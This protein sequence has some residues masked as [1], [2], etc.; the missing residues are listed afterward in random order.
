M[1]FIELFRLQRIIVHISFI[2]L[3][4]SIAVSD[5]ALRNCLLANRRNCQSRRFVFFFYCTVKVM[6]SRECGEVRTFAPFSRQGTRHGESARGF[7]FLIS[8]SSLSRPAQFSGDIA[9]P[10]FSLPFSIQRNMKVKSCR[11][12]DRSIFGVAT[13]ITNDTIHVCVLHCHV[14]RGALR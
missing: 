11:R 8:R 6:Q 12:T 4:V 14:L 7:F 9:P 1:L 5:D 13:L 3:E 10:T 2:F